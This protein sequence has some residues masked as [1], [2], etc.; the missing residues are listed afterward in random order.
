MAY[1][2]TP[3]QQIEVAR[4][5][6][7]T[8]DAVAETALSSMLA[9]AQGEQ[10]TP[11][12]VANPTVETKTET[13]ETANF[14]Q[15]MIETS[16]DWF[17]SVT[18]GLGKAFEGVVDFGAG[19]VG[20]VAGWFG[21]DELK[22]SASD[23]VETDYVGGWMHELENNVEFFKFSNSF[24]N[25]MSEKG[26][27]IVRGVGEGVGQM[28]PLIAITALTGGVAAPAAGGAATASATAAGATAAQAAAAGAKAAK[29]IS[30]IGKVV[31]MGLLGASAAGT[32]TEQ[33]LN[34]EIV[35]EDGTTRRPTLDR[36]FL[37]GLASGAVEMATE[38][39]V[40]GAYSKVFGGGVADK[41]INK[42]AKSTGFSKAVSFALNAL[43]EG[44]EEV[45]SE[46]V[47][48]T[49]QTI[50]NS[51][52]GFHWEDPKIQDM[53]E[54][55]VIGTL[56]SAVM[57]GGD[58]AVR[59]MSNTMSVQDHVAEA[60]DIE[61]KLENLS[62]QESLDQETASKLQAS[63][64]KNIDAIVKRYG[65][66]N[67]K[68]KA[69]IFKST[70]GIG[71][72][73]NED[74][75]RR[76]VE[77][78]EGAQAITSEESSSPALS[79]ALLS[80]TNE[81]A[82]MLHAHGTTIA[83]DMTSDDIANTR[84][85]RTALKKA[86]TDTG[87]S[88]KV[89][90]ADNLAGAN[91]FIDGDVMYISKK[92]VGDISNVADDFAHESI[93]F[94]EG[95][96]EHSKL[97]QLFQ[98]T[99]MS[100]DNKSVSLW[101][102]AIHEVYKNTTA[103]GR[104]DGY[105]ISQETVDAFRKG[106]L[107]GLNAQQQK[108]WKLLYSEVSA[109]ASELV[110]G[111]SKYINELV[112]SDRSLTKAWLKKI[113]RTIDVV[114]A[115]F[116]GDKESA[117]A[118][119]WLQKAEHFFESALAA[120]G[121]KYLRGK[122]GARKDDD[123]IDKSDERQYNLG[124][125]ENGWNRLSK[126]EQALFYKRIDEIH[127]QKYQE[128][129]LPSGK[130][131]IDIENKIIISN[132]K[133]QTPSI[134]GIVEFA[135]YSQ[136]ISQARDYFYEQITNGRTIQESIEFINRVCQEEVATL[137]GYDDSRSHR[138]LDKQRQDV[139]N[140][141]TSN[142]TIEN[143][144]R[145]AEQTRRNVNKKNEQYSL[146]ST[147]DSEG[148][149]LS[150]NQLQFFKDSKVVDS[151]GNLLVVY[152]GTKSEFTVFDRAKGG[153]S[154][155]IADVGFWFIADEQ[156][157]LNWANSS[158]WGDSEKG[159][160]IPVYLKIN[161]PKIYESTNN[162]TS[163]LIDKVRE[164]HRKRAQ[165]ASKYLYDIDRVNYIKGFSE[166]DAFYCLV[167]NPQSADYF[168]DKIS[169]DKRKKVLSAVD[170]YKKIEAQEEAIE[171]QISELHYTSDG[172]QK[173]R[174]DLYKIAGQ[175]SEEAN[176]AGAGYALKNAAET[177]AKFVESLKKQ[178]YDGIV[179]HTDYDSNVF[180][181]NNTQYLVFD[182]NQ[183]KLTTN[184]NPTTN[185]DIRYSLVD[186]EPVKPTSDAWQPTID[187]EEAKR[188]FP[189]LWDVKADESE[190]RNPTQIRSTV[191]T[192]KKVYDILKDEGFKGTI[193]DASSGLGYGTK[194]GI[195]EYGFNIDD[196]EPYPDKSYS[197]KY[198]D[199]SRLTK[200]YDVI[201]SN[202]VLN[203]LPQDQR[204]ALVVKMGELLKDGGRIFINVRGDDVNT[205]ASNPNNVKIGDM[206]WFVSSTGSYQKGFTRAELVAYLQDAL[207]DNFTVTGTTK[208]GKAAAIVEKH[209][210]ANE[211]IRYNLGD[212]NIGKKPTFTG[213]QAKTIANNSAKK[214][215]SRQDAEEVITAIVSEQ[216][217]MEDEGKY[218]ELRGKGKE[219]VVDYLFRKFNSQDNKGKGAVALEIADYLIDTVT[220]VDMDVDFYDKSED[221]NT[222]NVLKQYMHKM[223]LR[224][225]RDEIKYRYD[226]N[227]GVYLLWSAKKGEGMT[228][229]VVA[230]ELEHYGIYLKGN[231]ESELFF[232]I[233]DRYKGAKDNIKE[234]LKKQKL[235]DFG[236][237]QDIKDLRQEI[238]RE[239]LLAYDEKG[240]K[241]KYATE[242]LD[243]IEDLKAE[244]RKIKKEAYEYNSKVNAILDIAERLK[245]NSDKHRVNGSILE[246]AT[247]NAVMKNLSKIKYRS[248]IRKHTARKVL[249]SLTL[250][251]NTTN[252]LLN[253]NVDDVD[254]VLKKEGSCGYLNSDILTILDDFVKHQDDRK[255]LSLDEV[256]DALLVMKHI[257]HLIKNYDHVLIGEKSVRLKEAAEQT[258]Q[259]AS[260]YVDMHKKGK[261]SELLRKYGYNIIEPRT[262]LG[263]WFGYENNPLMQAYDAITAGET[264]SGLVT[265]ELITPIDEF[266]KDHRKYK[267]RL[268]K[269]KITVC[270]HE[271]TVGAAI[272][273][274]MLANQQASIEG[275][276]KSGWG[277][278]DNNGY[279]V[280]CGVMTDSD[281]KSL[282]EEL[283]Q[284]DKDF[285]KVI[286]KVLDK[287]GEYMSETDILLK[288]FTTIVTEN[289][290]YFPIRRYQ[291]DFARN[292][293]QSFQEYMMNVSV[294]NLGVTKARVEN[295]RR[296]AVSDVMS[297]LENHAKQ[298]GLYT[299]LAVP[300]KEFQR[301]YNA[302]IASTGSVPTSVRNILNEEV[303]KDAGNYITNLLADI[304]GMNGRKSG[305]DRLVEKVRG[306]YAKFQLGANIKVIFSQA[307]S[308]PTAFTD[309][310]LEALSK[311]FT[312]LPK[313][314]NM[315][316]YCAWARVRNYSHSV[317]LAESVTDKIGAVGDAFTKPIQWMDRATIKLLWNACQFEIEHRHKGDA[318]FKYGTEQN[319]IEAGKLL[320]SVGRRTQPNYTATERSALQRSQSQI[321]KT[322]SMFSSVPLKQISR[323][324]EAF[325]KE[326]VLRY[327]KNKL[328][329][330][331]SDA[332]LKSAHLYTAKA[333]TAVTVA[334]LVY[335]AMGEAIK[336]LLNKDRKDEEGNDIGLIEDFF[337]DFMST[338]VGMLPFV[339]D[340][341]NALING[342]DNEDFVSSGFNSFIDATKEVYDG[343]VLIASGE[344][345]ED[346]DIAAPIRSFA[347]ALGQLTGIPT[348][349]AYN[350]VYGLIKRFDPAKA[351]E[352]NSIFYS[353]ALYTRDLKSAVE[354][355]DENKATTI[356]GLMLKDDGMTSTSPIV[357]EKLRT[358]YE[359]GFSVLPRTVKDTVAYDGEVIELSRSSQKAFK[360]IY[361][362][363]NN[364]VESLVRSKA[365]TGL[366]DEV[367]AKAIKWIYDYY[368]EK[369]VTETIGVEANSKRQLFGETM[370]P[371]K[372][373]M[374]FAAC[375]AVE[376]KVDRKG[377]TIAGSK[378]AAITKLLNK[379]S[380]TKA[381]KAIILAY[382][383][384]SVEDYETLIKSFISRIGLTRTQQKAFLKYANL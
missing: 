152:H 340:I 221:L 174:A 298:V 123:D 240:V 1:T 153:A 129:R 272:S 275:L 309:L 374:A 238:A 158:W 53:F 63:Y 226:H 64:Q 104:V 131:V 330:K 341:Y 89:V 43:G 381:E 145:N 219:T 222:I 251:Y 345:I 352:M 76:T 287:S 100:D 125:Q 376:S 37:Y 343:A 44:A 337:R 4:N 184:K 349:N 321:A 137:F 286:R 166:W 366:S 249:A 254:A 65:R 95:T 117:S 192:Y 61:R 134:N 202:A 303:W 115:T 317:V 126:Q 318:S 172:Y 246:D 270:G 324:Y 21:N 16:L 109:K 359:A 136:L 288:G 168:L 210:T 206:E 120:S 106:S 55:G 8:N 186:V 290:D 5:R 68:T 373:A 80:R 87:A 263:D 379:L 118:L 128:Y 237:A 265:L 6:I 96:E 380:L 247:F 187:T 11:Q 15:R 204:D 350:L 277:Y 58:A 77:L 83:K 159:K 338:T 276:K 180:G 148:R 285:I 116:S 135:K 132:G 59:K 54:A 157:A 314:D 197:P 140:D 154:N 41:L 213:Q 262:V 316:K 144:A 75:S 127:H 271:I 365:F 245:P 78:D 252:P 112:E 48:N 18:V 269:D 23:F 150:P 279:W 162:D 188:R 189:T 289:S 223:D 208:F 255:P 108:E 169:E 45:V 19:A 10:S 294:A 71:A 143:R 114:K 346:K 310:S 31:N 301:I 141:N 171:K 119:R 336:Y 167:E 99:I 328:G 9:M 353:N 155:S 235:K 311:A 30:T 27:R 72:Y 193:L 175:T 191:S 198:T 377:N 382:L 74:G 378:R 20:T 107:E 333:I 17:K 182:S 253:G 250:W 313:G 86:G 85:L 79:Q 29:T 335:V 88:I 308:Y 215:Y 227:N 367:Q 105:K 51:E 315:D 47:S 70:P 94:A 111:N 293:D 232:E 13:P 384:Y 101:D 326:R 305:I 56:T 358:L 161:N 224:G 7:S 297:I 256:K 243:K 370:A 280:N 190:T 151:N 357:N 164:L 84:K 228:P 146:R 278:Y 217:L 364:E 103:N 122:M 362:T 230:Q 239:V 130:Y 351:Y 360:E 3:T 92:R 211:D 22:N 229:D 283:S 185:E 307:A 369:A 179:I 312:K 319:K 139:G 124:S 156:G 209:I 242:V 214:V 334:N 264:K 36:A 176:I 348:R 200:K 98:K 39:L 207:G 73:I 2:Y 244:I 267:T 93:H 233:I 50:Y 26:Q 97:A 40:G 142:G 196:I 133:F 234:S 12:A 302:N 178:G 181:K 291:G 282:E 355:G 344:P 147:T 325:G 160:A 375:S 327:R 138:Q 110:F 216:F 62:A 91:A 332:E 292:V 331:I 363:A 257:D 220:M 274:Y 69:K 329:E 52:E 165:I 268:A 113:K 383:G 320:E 38:T 173:F 32:G 323:L 281:I 34:Y 121:E 266:M 371:S 231:T 183:I 149:T 81:V 259:K 14:F 66:A 25:D 372:F 368:Y 258:C 273:L 356:I 90:V 306:S 296:I 203:V 225:I 248:D 300:I 28:L 194:A 342:F 33:A 284:A 295:Q 261:V 195:D 49:L 46:A 60:R 42:L 339:K 361:G 67:D 163:S 299:G 212:T 241:S 218:G 170:E 102:A 260:R 347:Y 322:F 199:Y 201:I 35:D 24:I 57:S 236:N 205:L 82:N 304:Q 177:K 354:K